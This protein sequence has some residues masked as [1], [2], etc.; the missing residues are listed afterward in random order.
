MSS[1]IDDTTTEYQLPL[2][3]ACTCKRCDHGLGRDC[4]KVKC[5]CCKEYNHSMVL[6]GIEGFPPTQSQTK[7]VTDSNEDIINAKAK[8]YR[9]LLI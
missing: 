7:D 2:D 5:T 8:V 9:A 1:P 3:S 6:D 4:L